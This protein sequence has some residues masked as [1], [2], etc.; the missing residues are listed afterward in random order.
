MSHDVKWH[1]PLF[2]F[3][4]TASGSS[5][6]SRYAQRS[7]PTCHHHSA[8]RQHLSCSFAQLTRNR[9]LLL[10]GLRVWLWRIYEPVPNRNHVARR[11]IRSELDARWLSYP[12]ASWRSMCSLSSGS[13]RFSFSLLAIGQFPWQ[14]IHI[15]TVTHSI[16]CLAS[17][18]RH[19][20][21]QPIILIGLSYLQSCN[22]KCIACSLQMC[23]F[24]WTNLTQCGNAN[25]QTQT[26]SLPYHFHCCNHLLTAVQ[27]CLAWE[28]TPAAEFNA[29][30]FCRFCTAYR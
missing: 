2:R 4:D 28:K 6:C 23:V 11:T 5:C 26:H 17:I 18:L 14:R 7:W 21:K 20:G 13:S 22:S 27:I 19:E 15:V 1:Q 29:I 24:Y 3:F 12:S 25:I 8:D 16:F 9:S 30:R 10:Q